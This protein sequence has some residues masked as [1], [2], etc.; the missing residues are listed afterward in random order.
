MNNK[1]NNNTY[2]VIIIGGGIVGTAILHELSKYNLK[3]ILIER[4]HDVS[5]G[6]TKGNSGVLHAGF[7][8]PEGSL[9]A[10]YNVE[11]L[12]LFR[13]LAQSLNISI[14]KCGKLV[15]AKNDSELPYLKRLLDQGFRNNVKG[16]SLINEK[17]IKQLQPNVRGKHAI[18]SEETSVLLPYQMAIALAENAVLNGASIVLNRAVNKIV[19][20]YNN[21]IIQTDKGEKYKSKIIINSAGLFAD[22]IID[23]LEEPKEK[24]FPWRGEYHLLEED[25]TS[26]I[27]MAVY[28]VPP[29][30]GSG[31]GVHITPTINGGILLGPSSDVITD[32]D[33]TSNTGK[34]LESL[35][36]EALELV[37]ALKPY[38]TIKNY[39]GVRPKLFGPSS[40]FTFKDFII[41]ESTK[42]PG[43]INLLGI[44]SPGLTA[45]PAIAKHLTED[46][47]S[48]YFPLEYKHGWEYKYRPI[49]RFK[50]LN[51]YEKQKLWE[52][53]SDFGDVLCQCEQVTRAEIKQAIY[54]PLGAVSLHAIRKRT[55]ATLGYCQSSFCLGAITRELEKNGFD[56]DSISRGNP[57]T[58]MFIGKEI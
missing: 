34:V 58:S 6:T 30:D 45:A 33:D 2:D 51:I 17:Q 1:I 50:W 56:L 41:E 53:D 5:E 43:M 27:N 52:I 15:V 36:K 12:K 55:H 54:N 13:E 44:E 3:T 4:Q 25:S 29:K 37:P 21:F 19:S 7:M 10:K 38:A 11:G 16:L 47:I 46:L 23:L 20:N 48:K 18:L 26:V 28:P 40:P 57:T 49:P 22:Q 8:V 31:L 42:Y 24:I 35:R 9:K 39:S 14:L 32:K